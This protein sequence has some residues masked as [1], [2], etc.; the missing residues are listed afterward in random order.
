[1]A[2]VIPFPPRRIRETTAYALALATRWERSSKTKPWTQPRARP[3]Q[4]GNMLQVLTQK[5]PAVVLVLESI[6]A[7]LYEQVEREG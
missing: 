2:K 1:M 6:V 7:D 5:R 4:L 3:E